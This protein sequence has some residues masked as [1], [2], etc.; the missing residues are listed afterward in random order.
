MLGRKSLTL[1]FRGIK[2]NLF[3]AKKNNYYNSLSI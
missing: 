1:E 3:N 2:V